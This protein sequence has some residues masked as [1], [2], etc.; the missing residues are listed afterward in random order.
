MLHSYSSLCEYYSYLSS[1]NNCLFI[2]DKLTPAAFE[3]HSGRETSRKWKN[4]IWIIVNGE[5]VPLYKTVLLKYYNKTSKSTNGSNRSHNGKVC[6]RDEFV[7]CTDCNKERRFRLRTKE[8]C[9]SYH[10]ALAD[11]DW[12]CS[13]M[14]Y[15]KYV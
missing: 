13:D 6:H 8:E 7:R 10:D 11:P 5:K 2:L 4:N 1:I 3:K 12:K 9:Q 14:P 15:D